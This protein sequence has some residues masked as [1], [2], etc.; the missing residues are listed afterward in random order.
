MTSQSDWPQKGASAPRANEAG[1]AALGV[2]ASFV[3]DLRQSL[4]VFAAI[5]AVPFSR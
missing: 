5:P 1:E 3:T 2:R 4:P